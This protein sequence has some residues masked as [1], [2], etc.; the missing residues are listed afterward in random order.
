[1]SSDDSVTMTKVKMMSLEYSSNALVK[2]PVPHSPETWKAPVIAPKSGTMNSNSTIASAGATRR[3]PVSR[4]DIRNL[5]TVS[6]EVLGLKHVQ[7]ST[8]I[9]AVGFS[10]LLDVHM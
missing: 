6:I 4:C 9:E 1:M 7:P 3:N 5:M 2:L 8:P 10:C